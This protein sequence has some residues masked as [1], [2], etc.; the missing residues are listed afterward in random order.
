MLKNTAVGFLVSFLGSLPFGYLN[1][2]GFQVYAEKGFESLIFY[3]LGVIIVE[4][5][6]IYSTLLFAKKFEY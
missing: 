4:S 5:V 6:V 3:L 2:I 1:L